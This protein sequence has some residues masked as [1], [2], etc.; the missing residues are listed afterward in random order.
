[1]EEKDQ[2]MQLLKQKFLAKMKEVQTQNEDRLREN[3]E[4][5]VEAEAKSA[6]TCEAL[7]KSEE[8]NKNLVKKL[9]QDE[10]YVKST[11]KSKQF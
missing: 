7:Q 6:E 9:Q 2:Q 5:L 4:K 10:E 1:M 11:Q 8:T 3:N